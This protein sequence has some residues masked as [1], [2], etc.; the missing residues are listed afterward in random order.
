MSLVGLADSGYFTLVYYG[1]MPADSHLIPKTC[2]MEQGA[3]RTVLNSEYA[4]VFRV[5]NSL[6]GLV[7]YAFTIVAAVMLICGDR[8]LLA[9]A[10]VA[11]LV[12]VA[13]SAYLAVA[14]VSRVRLPCPLCFLAHGVNL[15]L[16]VLLSVL[17]LLT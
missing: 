4:R 13:F 11:S 9:Y 3:C 8:G 2:R 5:P 15:A 16:L 7:Y 14:L 12:S 17:A 1:R 10:F 6:L